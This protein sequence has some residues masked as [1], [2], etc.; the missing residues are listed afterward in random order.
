MVRWWD[1]GGRGWVV[2]EVVSL[3]FGL[4][5][6][7]YSKGASTLYHYLFILLPVKIFSRFSV[8]TP[9]GPSAGVATRPGLRRGGTVCQIL[10]YFALSQAQI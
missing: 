6:P 7:M 9:P 3:V 1:V 4:Y 8:T 2:P 10:P 5:F